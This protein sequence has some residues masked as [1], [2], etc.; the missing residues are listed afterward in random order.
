LGARLRAGS[1]GS[2]S[3]AASSAS[4]SLRSSEPS[5]IRSSSHRNDGDDLETQCLGGP[6]TET[7][8][9]TPLPTPPQSPTT[10]KIT[11]LHLNGLDQPSIDRYG[12]NVNKLQATI[13]TLQS[14]LREKET[15]CQRLREERR[16]ASR[17]HRD[18]IHRDDEE[19]IE[20]LKK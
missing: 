19:E 20:K 12:N 5:Q 9:P 6:M 3:S 16:Q 4:G 7:D 1:S 11:T 14:K 2:E 13:N 18:S 10:S 15:E 8:Q 17:L